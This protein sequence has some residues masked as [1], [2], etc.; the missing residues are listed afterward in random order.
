MANTNTPLT[1]RQT[2]ILDAISDGGEYN[3]PELIAK[4]G[5]PRNGQESSKVSWNID[6]LIAREMVEIISTGKHRVFQITTHGK[7]SVRA[8]KAHQRLYCGVVAPVR[9]ALSERPLYVPPKAY[10]RNDGNAHIA[11]RGF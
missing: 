8:E 6:R 3:I 9:I 11:S 7:S 5:L 2:K 1:E 4:M 10:Y